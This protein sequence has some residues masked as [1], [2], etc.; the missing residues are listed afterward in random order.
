MS[1]GYIKTIDPDPADDYDSPWKEAL[2]IYFKDF[3]EF[4]FP[5]IADDINWVRGYK[6]R[7][8]EFQQ[9]VRNA[10]IGRRYADKLVSVWSVR[11]DEINVM[12][13]IEIQA[14]RDINFPERMYVYNYRIYDKYQ[15]P[16]T[17]LAILADENAAWKPRR[18]STDQWGCKIDF[19]FPIVKLRELGEDLDTLLKNLNPFAM[20]TAA[21]LLT[22]ISKHDVQSRYD[23]KWK[24]TRMLYE[25]NY[26]REQIL[27]LY[28]FI[29]W[30]MVLPESLSKKFINQHKE[31]EE[32][33]KMPFITT[34]EKIGREEGREEGMLVDAREMVL[35]A[36]DI[37]FSNVSEDIH[38]QINALNNRILL[39]RLHQA[40]IRS[41]DIEGFKKTIREIISEPKP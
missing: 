6:F 18:F 3:M 14:D 7:D 27:N 20:I 32:G 12:I 1:R 26:T 35:E 19:Q 29:D 38:K 23:G 22:Q 41:K 11:G 24:L 37:K 16:V 13:H 21:H 39:K 28:R 17:S 36:L 31:Y 25:K 34:A 33:K 2:E 10:E 30:L 15:K 8:K 5:W 40:A 4:F 9:I